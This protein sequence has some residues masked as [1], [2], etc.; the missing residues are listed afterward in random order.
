MSLSSVFSY[1]WIMDLKL[2]D[3][4]GFSTTRNIAKSGEVLNWSGFSPFQLHLGLILNHSQSASCH[5]ATVVCHA[6]KANAQ[7]GTFGF[8]RPTSKT[9]KTKRAYFFAHARTE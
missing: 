5:I 1:F 7:I 8:C 4:G 6:E 3:E 9:Q 2:P